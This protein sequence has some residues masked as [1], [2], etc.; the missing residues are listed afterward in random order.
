MRRIDI[1]SRA[2]VESM[3]LSNLIKTYR[4]KDWVHYVG[5]FLLGY[6]LYQSNVSFS[7][8]LQVLEVSL[9]L[10]YAYS[11]N[12]FFDAKMPRKYA[13]IPLIPLILAAVLMPAFDVTKDVLIAGFIILSTLYS[14][15]RIRLKSFPIVGSMSNNLGF[16]L[17]FLLGAS[18]N[19]ASALTVKYFLL[20]FFLQSAAQFIHEISHMKEDE[21][22]GL[23]T[24]ALF[25][26]RHRTSLTCMALLGFASVTSLTLFAD[27]KSA[28]LLIAPTMLFSSYFAYDLSRNDIDGT[29]KRFK[30]YG[31]VV[32][33]L[34]LLNNFLAL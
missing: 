10:S 1:H 6:S 34:Y 9:V 15:P 20:V 11:V 31:T 2:R 30:L 5:L 18:A 8:I 29:R 24:T 7:L 17:I 25:L 4:I 16:L 12:Q 32:G 13:Y 21:K 19:L 14:A 23:T 3:R 26:G 22:E 33:A 27:A 28:L